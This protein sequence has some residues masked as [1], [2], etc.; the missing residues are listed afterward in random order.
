M[1]ESTSETVVE[2][3][4]AEVVVGAEVAGT[5]PR[6]RGSKVVIGAGVVGVDDGGWVV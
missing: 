4:P 1:D 2:S 6:V 3:V 5:A